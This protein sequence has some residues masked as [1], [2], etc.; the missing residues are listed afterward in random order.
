MERMK[1]RKL[2]REGWRRSR[3]GMKLVRGLGGKRVSAHKSFLREIPRPA[4]ES[5][6]LRDDA[7]P[8]ADFET[9]TMRVF[10]VIIQ[11][12]D[13]DYFGRSA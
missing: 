2:G 8:E 7:R 13:R 10:L 6:D 5:A 4:G 3:F 9:E 1:S 12:T 11:L